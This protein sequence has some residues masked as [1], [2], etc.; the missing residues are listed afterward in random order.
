MTKLNCN[1]PCEV[2]AYIS[3]CDGDGML[4]PNH[5]NEWVIIQNREEEKME[6]QYLRWQQEMLEEEMKREV[7]EEEESDILD[8]M[9]LTVVNEDGFVNVITLRNVSSIFS[10]LYRVICSGSKE[11]CLSI[12][13][14]YLKNNEEEK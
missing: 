10:S 13:I 6:A 1:D 4:K 14:T 7:K 12:A 5:F 3:V 11:R 9:W 2:C 8:A